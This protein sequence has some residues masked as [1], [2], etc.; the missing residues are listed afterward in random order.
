VDRLVYC[1]VWMFGLYNMG[2][3]ALSCLCEWV[4]G[5][6]ELFVLVVALW[7]YV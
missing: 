6:L 3:V 1:W 4:F 2:L 7:V 5:F